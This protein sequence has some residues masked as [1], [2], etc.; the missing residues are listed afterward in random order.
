MM[1]AH[2]C[3]AIANFRIMEIDV[4]DVPWKDEVAGPPP[5]IEAGHLILPEGP[6]W[7]VEV[8]TRRRSAP[9]RRGAARR[10]PMTPPVGS[11]LA[12]SRPAAR[13]ERR[14]RACPAAAMGA[15][16]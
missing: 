7:G 5:V 16:A 4:D 10:P 11:G 1:N 9:T 14:R 3:A 15:H 12:E 13:A 2:F 6:G 8:R